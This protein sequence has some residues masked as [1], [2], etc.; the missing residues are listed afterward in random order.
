M[1]RLF[2]AGEGPNELGR[3]ALEPAYRGDDPGALEALLTA[4]RASG[5]QVEDAIRWQDIRKY[6]VGAHGRGEEQNVRRAWHHAHHERGCDA[7]AFTRDRD[8]DK[9]RERT[10]L[11][12]VA[13]LESNGAT[14]AGGVAVE[15]LESWLLAIA[16]D[17]RTESLGRL[18]A[19][20][21]LESKHGVGHKNTGQMV[22]LIQRKGLGEVP[23]DARS[24][25]SWLEKARSILSVS[26]AI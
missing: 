6:V 25:R 12:T 9:S 16:G 11:D 3:W 1:I 7:L 17:T 18:K 24:L 21:H 20:E 22:E 13:E 15:C 8:G 14:I 10:I 4:V 5:W 23:D 19:A 2:L 26:Q